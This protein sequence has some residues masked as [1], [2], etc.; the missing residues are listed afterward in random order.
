MPAATAACKVNVTN[1]DTEEQVLQRSTIPPQSLTKVVNDKLRSNRIYRPRPKSKSA[2]TI[3]KQEDFVL[4][5][6]DKSGLAAPL[7]WAAVCTEVEKSIKDT[8]VSLL[9]IALALGPELSGCVGSGSLCLAAAGTYCISTKGFLLFRP[10]E[11][12]QW[13]FQCSQ[14]IWKPFDDNQTGEGKKCLQVRPSLEVIIASA[15]AVEGFLGSDDFNSVRSLASGKERSQKISIPFISR[16]F[17]FSTIKVDIAAEGKLSKAFCFSS[18]VLTDGEL[19]DALRLLC[20]YSLLW[21]VTM[22]FQQPV[23]QPVFELSKTS[24][25]LLGTKQLWRSPEA[26][27]QAVLDQAHRLKGF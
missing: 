3:I 5:I 6:Q 1:E 25:F 23:Q 15:E 10:R 16:F 2:D 20:P 27:Q 4:E 13:T 7:E 22:K 17:G 26:K 8:E 11:A 21:C 14:G 9:F 19:T 24:R 12:T 18:C